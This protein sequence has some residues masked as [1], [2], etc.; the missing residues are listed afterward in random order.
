MK[1]ANHLLLPLV[2]VCAAAGV[3]PPVLANAVRSTVSA[4][5]NAWRMPGACAPRRPLD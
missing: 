5:I 4:G 3:R 2:A 1:T